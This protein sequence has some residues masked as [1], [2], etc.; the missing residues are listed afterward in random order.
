MKPACSDLTHNSGVGHWLVVDLKSSDVGKLVV[1][2][3][4]VV[5]EP[6][7]EAHRGTH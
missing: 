3:V 4:Q 6:I 5:Y 1:Y 7:R 2:I